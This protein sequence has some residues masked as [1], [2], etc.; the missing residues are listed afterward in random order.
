ME[1]MILQTSIAPNL[2]FQKK[3]IHHPAQGRLGSYK[4]LKL[5]KYQQ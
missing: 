3:L 5:E 1:Q 4:K 2:H